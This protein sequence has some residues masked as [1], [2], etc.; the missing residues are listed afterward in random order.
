MIDVIEA[1]VERMLAHVSATEK[2]NN[3]G[4]SSRTK[5]LLSLLHQL[6][7]GA[8]QGEGQVVNERKDY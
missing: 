1:E 6:K 7:G 8:K 3:R 2:A 5:K 4:L